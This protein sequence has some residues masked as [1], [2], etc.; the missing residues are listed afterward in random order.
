MDKLD[1]IRERQRRSIERQLQK[2]EEK[3][4]KMDTRSAGTA[5]RSTSSRGTSSRST[6]SASSTNRNATNRTAAKRRSSKRKKSRTNPK[7]HTI[8]KIAAIAFVVGMVTAIAA[9]VWATWGMDFDFSKSFNRLGLELSSVVYYT[10]ENGNE[11]IYE[12]LIADENRIWADFDKIPQDM[13]NAFVAIEDQRFYKHNGV[14][15]K[16]T[17]GAAVN[18]IFN[19]D[20]SY[21]GSTITQQLIKNITEDSERSK[22]RKIREIVR[23]LILETKMDKDEILELYMNSIYLGHGANGVQAA[24]HAYFGKD[25]RDLSLVECTAIAGITQHP[26]TYDPYVNPDGN[27]QKRRRV[28]DKML[29]LKYIDQATYDEAYN[30]ELK[31][32]DDNADTR[33]SQS[34]F[35]DNL[36]EE[37]LH[38]L[39]TAKGYTKQYATGLIYNGGLK[40]IST[41]DPE[42][43][44]IMND[45]Y[46]SGNGFPKFY[47]QSPQSAMIITDPSTGE[48]K[49]LVGGTGVKKGARVLN[50][51]T[52]TYRQPGSTIKPISVY[53]PAIDNGVVTLASS[54]ENSPLDL[55]GWKPNNASKKFSPPVSVRTAVAYSYN[56]PAI[57][58]LEEL[59][60][61]KS[62]DYMTNKLH[63]DLVQS[64]ND[65]NTTLTDKGFAPLA[66]GGLT[67]GVTVAQMNAAYSTFANGGE[68][69]KPY[70]YTKV[71]D[72]NG[73]LI[74]DKTPERNKAFSKETAFLVTQLLK[75]VV[76][77]G[78]AAGSGLRGIETCGKTGSTDDNMDR[79]FVG[80]TPYYSA[81]V[82]VGYDEQRV[83]SYAGN[84]PALTI[85]SAVMKRVHEDLPNKSFEQPST[86]KKAYICTNS[87][88]YATSACTGVSDFANTK[89]I[90]GYCDGIHTYQ[91]GTPGVLEEEEKKEENSEGE[92]NGEGENNK[93]D[94][95]TE[96]NPPQTND[97]PSDDTS[98]ES[99]ESTSDNAA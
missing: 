20:S 23:A 2:E 52:Q 39:M 17:M 45:V 9:V 35:V 16:R 22:A 5:K 13:K 32:V 67:E 11:Q 75:G 82:W 85:W 24:A 80:Y 79:W 86:V 88:Q 89:L 41:V 46:V 99:G 49:G 76:Q 55:G 19:G 38:D 50:R 64:K 70:S 95:T 53:G 78:T 8:F 63:F 10:D 21:G 48:I 73:K 84:N 36:F 40:I 57:R 69:I 93:S 91:L 59:T 81:A 34:Y 7:M 31:L 83:I 3:T 98:T 37:L 54:V 94:E 74:L 18:V 66:L 90:S 97:A 47:G 71:Y 92:E 62:F 26:S 28:L 87:G 29:E 27:K 14:D 51:A 58:V 4:A 1:S 43:Q 61:D 6:S 42:I 12:Q 65:G 15:I 44:R 60:V 25:V 77:S 68:Y 56:L 30:T 96:E 33:Y 72:T